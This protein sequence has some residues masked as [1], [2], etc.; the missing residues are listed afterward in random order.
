VTAVGWV[1]AGGLLLKILGPVAPVTGCVVAGGVVVGLELF[2][3]KRLVPAPVPPMAPEVPPKIPVP[4]VLVL[5]PLTLP[6]VFAPVLPV[7]VWFAKR[8][9]PVVGVVVVAA[10]VGTV[11]GAVLVPPPPKMPFPLVPVLTALGV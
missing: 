3:A 2:P 4:A 8:L 1:E 7:F 5:I 6:P 9:T 10:G 11:L